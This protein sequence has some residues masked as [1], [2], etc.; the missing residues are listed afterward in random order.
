M[1][2]AFA[3]ISRLAGDDARPACDGLVRAVGAD[4]AACSDAVKKMFTRT[5]DGMQTCLRRHLNPADIGGPP[6]V[7][8]L[9]LRS[10]L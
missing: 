5:V 7:G 8:E 6:G 3:E 2:K 4:S 10:L 1:A 9:A